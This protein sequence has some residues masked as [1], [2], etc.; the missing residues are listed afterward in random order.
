MMPYKWLRAWCS[1]CTP[2]HDFFS[3][4]SCWYFLVC[5]LSHRQGLIAVC[6]RK[7]ALGACWDENINGTISAPKTHILSQPAMEATSVRH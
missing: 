7:G 3:H 1:P 5:F 6:C 2:S 4:P